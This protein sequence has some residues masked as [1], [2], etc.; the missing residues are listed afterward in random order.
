MHLAFPRALPHLAGTENSSPSCHGCQS[1]HG[2]ENQ[3]VGVPAQPG[4]VQG[5]LLS[6]IAPRRKGEVGVAARK[7]IRFWESLEN[8]HGGSVSVFYGV[9]SRLESWIR[10][11]LLTEGW[12]PCI[13]EE[14]TLCQLSEVHLYFKVSSLYQSPLA[15]L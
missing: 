5:H 7:E 10:N 9:G 6:K 11:D 2:S 15:G 1:S 14:L 8:A 13:P 12:E 4:K 3:Q